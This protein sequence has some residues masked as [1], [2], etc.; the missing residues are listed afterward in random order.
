MDKQFLTIDGAQVEIKGESN[1]LTVCRRIGVE[2]PTFCYH[3]ELSVFGACRMCMVDVAGR[4]I[5]PSCSTKP[6]PNMVVLTNTKQIR[7]M[8][9]INLELLLASHDQQCT[10]C[11]KSTDCKLQS[12]AKKMG[13]ENVRYKA[14]PR[15]RAVDDSSF[16]LVR[17]QSKCILCGNCVRMCNE[18]QTVGALN[19][20]YRGARATAG[21]AF[22]KKLSES[23]CVGCGQCVKVCPV[24]ALVVKRQIDGVWGAIYDKAKVVAVQIAPAVRVALAEQFGGAAGEL[25]TGKIVTALRAIGVDYVYDT[26]FAADLTVV[27]EGREFLERKKAGAN[28]PMFTSCCPAWVKF[29]E[30]SYPENIKHFSSCRSPQQML[31]SVLKDTMPKKLGIA[32]ENLVVVSVMPCVAKKIEAGRDEF[33]SGANPDVDFVI[34]STELAAMIRERGLDFDRLVD[35]EFDKPYGEFSGAGVIFGASGGVSEAV[36]RFAAN[37]LDKGKKQEFKQL[38]AEGGIK[39]TE[40][41]IGG[42]PLRLAVVSGLGNACKL[43]EKIHTGQEHFDIMEVMACPNG[44]VNG[45]GQPAT[46][47]CGAVLGRAKALYA[48]DRALKAQSADEN[49]AIAALYRD[50]LTGDK[51]HKILHT[52]YKGGQ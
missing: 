17:D 31:G 7:D 48:N 3:P 35:G 44:C 20:S 47:V 9:K 30:N 43:L 1:I 52:K 11:A 10:T 39:I 45:G 50:V 51:A 41:T 26:C 15:S 28:L 40:V 49:P 6:E 2:I 13:V 42:V 16:A 12:L 18:I 27:E 33:K 19:F 36:L 37:T 38:R 24:G 21:T 29:I 46:D 32:R 22:N 5:V 34:T 8:R 25:S 4:G 23:E 14:M